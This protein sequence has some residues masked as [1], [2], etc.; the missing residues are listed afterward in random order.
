[1]ATPPTQRRIEC[2][3]RGD[4]YGTYDRQ[5]AVLGRV[6]DLDSSGV[7]SETS[8][9]GD[10]QRIRTPERDARDEA[11]ETYEEFGDWARENGYSLEPA[12]ERRYR[13]Y[14]G[15]S[16]VDEVVVFPVVSLAVYD[17]TDLEAVFPCSDKDGSVHYTVGDCLDVLERGGADEWLS[18]FRRLSVDRVEPRLEPATL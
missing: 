14:L 12:F 2:Y 3:L 17:G 16:A 8:V 9:T 10:W 6:S 7:V 5:Q 13:A 4:T 1:M 15:R 18:D 11:I